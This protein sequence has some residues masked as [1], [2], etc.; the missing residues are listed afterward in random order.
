MLYHMRTTLNIDT[1]LMTRVREHAAATG[2][3]ITETVE[4]ALRAA[5]AGDRPVRRKHTLRWTP[6]PGRML[7]GIDLADRDTLYEAME[8]RL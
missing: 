3:T 5:V 2:R 6:V 1:D 8:R 7:P 4:E